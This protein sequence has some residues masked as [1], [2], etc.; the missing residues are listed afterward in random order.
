LIQFS[1]V[2]LFACQD[3]AAIRTELQ[4]PLPVSLCPQQDNGEE[5]NKEDEQTWNKM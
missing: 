4:K 5:I 3:L 2:L 1:Y